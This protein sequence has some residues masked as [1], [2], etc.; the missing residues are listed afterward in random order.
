MEKFIKDFI[1]FTE[2]I[3]SEENSSDAGSNSDPSDGNF[4]PDEIY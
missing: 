1:T 2:K 3:R 4:E